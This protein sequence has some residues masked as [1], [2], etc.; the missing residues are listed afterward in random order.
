MILYIRVYMY[1]PDIGNPV[2]DHTR[3]ADAVQRSLQLLHLLV[4]PIIL[5]LSLHF[6]KEP[7]ARYINGRSGF[8]ILEK[9]PRRTFAQTFTFLKERFDVTQEGPL[10]TVLTATHTNTRTENPVRL[11]G[12]H[13]RWSLLYRR[14]VFLLMACD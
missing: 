1:F 11:A 7:C 5:L 6:I 2:T 8:F 3:Y 14:W 10:P 13:N 4:K 9:H 12:H